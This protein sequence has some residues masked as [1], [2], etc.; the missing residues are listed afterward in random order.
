MLLRQ[1]RETPHSLTPLS[2]EREFFS[3]ENIIQYRTTD[4]SSGHQTAWHTPNLSYSSLP[5]FLILY[6]FIIMNPIDDNYD[7]FV[8]YSV[9]PLGQPPDD[10]LSTASVDD[11]ISWGDDWEALRT[12]SANGSDAD[13]IVPSDKPSLPSID[14]ILNKEY[15]ADL[16]ADSESESEAYFKA[17]SYSKL[18]NSDSASAVSL[19]DPSLSSL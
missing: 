6:H 3:P 9:P 5:S 13:D 10:D 17:A 14:K 16:E 7:A 4:T 2:R 15:I 11:D 8:T 1:A 18:S 19:E 12:Y